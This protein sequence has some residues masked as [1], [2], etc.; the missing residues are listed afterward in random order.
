MTSYNM[1]QIL[2]LNLVFSSGNKNPLPVVTVSLWRSNKQM[3]TII[4][5]L[6]HMWGVRA[7]NIMI[8]RRNPK[9]NKCKIC[10]NKVE[11]STSAGPYY[12]MRGA[13]VQFS[14]RGFLAAR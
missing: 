12:T 14:C 9:P 1:I 10:S 7:T 11:Y 13:K 3:E 4:A 2:I 6:K 5:R 8:K